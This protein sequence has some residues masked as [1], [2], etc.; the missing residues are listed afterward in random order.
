[1]TTLCSL[2]LP[3]STYLPLA[4]QPNLRLPLVIHLTTYISSSLATG[5]TSRDREGSIGIGNGGLNGGG[6]QEEPPQD[7]LIEKKGSDNG[8]RV[9]ASFDGGQGTRASFEEGQGVGGRGQAQGQGLVIGPGGSYPSEVM[10][11]YFELFKGDPPYSHSSY[12]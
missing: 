4:L 5:S 11:R 8:P 9:R 10:L 7:T 6:G 1:M 2:I 3:T 12:I